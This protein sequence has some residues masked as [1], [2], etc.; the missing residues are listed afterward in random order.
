MQIFLT[1][2]N[3]L[4]K[5][6]NKSTGVLF[7]QLF[8]LNFS[9]TGEHTI[10]L[11]CHHHLKESWI[12]ELHIFTRQQQL[13]ALRNTSAI[14]KT[15]G[16]D[17]LIAGRPHYLLWDATFK[18]HSIIQIH[19]T[20]HWKGHAPDLNWNNQASQMLDETSFCGFVSF[21]NICKLCLKD[22]QNN[23]SGTWAIYFWRGFRLS[24]K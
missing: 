20:E 19:F 14:W 24:A 6:S 16:S 8:Y 17:L 21:D 1:V 11:I 12:Y 5:L 23:N 2:I 9:H 13:F 4:S 22:E 10:C 18:F 3:R 7:S 15:V